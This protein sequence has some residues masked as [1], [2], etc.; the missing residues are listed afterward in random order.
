MLR[1]ISKN[2]R[3]GLTTVALFALLLAASTPARAQQPAQSPVQPQAPSANNPPAQSAPPTGANARAATPDVQAQTAAQPAAQTQAQAQ[4]GQP[5]TQ[6]PQPGQT[7]VGQQPVRLEDVPALDQLNAPGVIAQ[8]RSTTINAPANPRAPGRETVA[9]PSPQALPLSVPEV[10]PNFRAEPQALPE[11][12]RVGVRMDEQR[13]LALR[14]AIELALKNGKD[15]EVARENVRVAEFDLVGARGV[16]DPRLT[17][18]SYYERTDT[19]SSSF[20]SGG[21]NGA[22]TQ[23]NLVGALSLQ[24]LTPKG[25]GG[26]RFDFSSIRLTTN[27][28]FAALNPQYPTAFTFSYTQPIL[29]GLRF[30][31]NRRAIEIAK[32]NLSL[33]DAQFRQRAIETIT[34]VQRAYW[35]LVF[36]LRNLQIQ[37]DAVTD[38]RTQYE[39]NK[40]LVAEGQLAPIDVVAAE[41]QVSGFEQSV[42]SALD[43]VNRAENNLKNLIAE[44]RTSAVWNVAIVPTDTVDLQRPPVATLEEAMNAAL[45]SRPELQQ[46]DV[47]VAINELDQRLAREQTKPQLDLV[48]SYGAVGLAGTLDPSRAVNPFGAAS[49]VQR[50]TINQLITTVNGLTGTNDIQ[51][52]PPTPTQSFPGFLVGGYSQSL[53]NLVENRFNNFRVGVQLNLPLRN[54]TAEAQLGRTLVEGERIRTQREQL[55]ELIQVDVRNALQQTRTAGSRLRAASI[56]RSASEQQYASELRKFDA[57]QSTFFLV[58]ERQTALATARGNELRAQT[59][60]N[61]SI[62]ELQRATGNSLEANQVHVSVR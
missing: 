37:R 40:R 25:G 45:K 43:E 59:E 61:K 50:Q 31:Q 13:P 38:A 21:A 58:L 15:I 9:S 57:G 36:A 33:T 56:A 44:D 10:A 22:V 48:G 3:R 18:S 6:T 27:N 46:S 51:L 54:R 41:A 34:Q 16:Y 11:L 52:I 42:Y 32:K 29:R 35:D 60:L 30:D 2:L 53:T 17:S 7:N 20:L 62:A 19:P 49:E 4:Q 28:Q 47:L 39:H 14:E 12:G 26:Y 55:E 5:Q 8:P 23:T 1:G 24:G